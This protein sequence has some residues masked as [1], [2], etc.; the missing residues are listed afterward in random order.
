MK[1]KHRPFTLIAALLLTGI[2]IGQSK[3]PAPVPAPGTHVDST[4]VGDARED[5]SVD[6]NNA[7]GLDND[8]HFEAGAPQLAEMAKFL[9]LSAQ[10]KTQLRDIFER[11]DAGAAVLIKRE[12]DVEEMLVKTPP[13]DPLFAQ[14][15][16]E[17]AAAPGRWQANRENLHQEIRAILAPAQQAKYEQLKT[18]RTTVPAQATAPAQ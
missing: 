11:A 1:Q 3:D 18:E 4:V 13:Q 5:N 14:L 10:Q 6:H 12:H 16:A 7:G 8:H 9:S 2:A 17:Q 15:R